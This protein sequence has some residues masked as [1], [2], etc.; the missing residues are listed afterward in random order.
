MVSFTALIAAVSAVSGVVASPSLGKRQNVTPNAEGTHNGYFYSWWS[1]GSS[2]ATYTNG[3]GGSYSVTWSAG[4]NLVGGKGW[5][6]GTA[7][8]IEYTADWKPVN[9]GNSVSGGVCLR[10]HLGQNK[11]P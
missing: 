1:D 11:A 6:P 7:R 2:P 4:G 3:D 5:N 10:V 9:N 8:S